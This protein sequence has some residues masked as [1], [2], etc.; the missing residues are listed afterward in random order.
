MRYIGID[1]GLSGGLATISSTGRV[2]AQSMPRTN[3]ELLDLVKLWTEPYDVRAVVELV[4]GYIGKGGPGH[5]GASMFNFGRGY[6]G[7]LMALDALEI[8]HKEVTATKWQSF[9]GIE[10]RRRGESKTD[11]KNRLKD[12]AKQL[13]PSQKVT[14]AT[15]DALLIAEYCRQTFGSPKQRV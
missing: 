3:F 13:F 8:E 10:K 14:L 15:S 7:I 6:G 5:P 11:W 12:T 9:L 4:T 2:Q 1:P